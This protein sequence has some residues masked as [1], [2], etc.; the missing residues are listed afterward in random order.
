MADGDGVEGV[1]V[2]AGTGVAGAPSDNAA[3][4]GAANNFCAVGLADCGVDAGCSGGEAAGAER[5]ESEKAE[6]MLFLLGGGTGGGGVAASG[7]LL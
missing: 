1:G 7:R 2:D 6:K 4:A 5:P 3:G